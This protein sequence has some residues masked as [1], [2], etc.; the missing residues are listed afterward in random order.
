MTIR[1]CSSTPPDTG[2][3]C[4]RP[5]ARTVA[6]S[7][8]CRGRTKSRS[9]SRSTAVVVAMLRG[10]A[11]R[12][13]PGQ[14]A[15]GSGYRAASARPTGEEDTVVTIDW[16]TDAI[17]LRFLAEEERPLRLVDLRPGAELPAFVGPEPYA[18]VHQP[19]VEVMSPHFGN[20]SSSNSVRHSGTHLGGAL[21]YVRNERSVEDATEVLTI[22]QVEPTTGLTTST[23]FTAARGVAA[24]RTTTTVSVAD[25]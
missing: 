19:L 24:V 3:S 23:R 1:P 17:S 10:M 15:A 20:D 4:G 21:R 22:E 12:L 18:R 14:V 8:L 6:S 25:G 9:C 13:G 5:S 11:P 7:I 2:D 16:T